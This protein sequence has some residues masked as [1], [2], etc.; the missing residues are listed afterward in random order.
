[1]RILVTGGAGFIGGRLAEA[2]L[3]DG[4]DVTVLDSMDPF[5]DLGIKEH[6]RSHHRNIADREGVEYAFVDGGIRDADLVTELVADADYVYHQAG[7]AGVR[8][9]I[10]APRE[11]HTVN[12]DG[13]A[14]VFHGVWPADA[15]E[16]GDL[17]LR[18]AVF[19]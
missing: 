1:M 5:Y 13:R 15:T 6:T 16:Y 7:K 2:L 18:L 11:Y 4:Y 8:S 19:Q 3:K 14:P 12:T 17:E 10:E 9:S